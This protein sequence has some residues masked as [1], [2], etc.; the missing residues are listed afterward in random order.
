M[1]DPSS[2]PSDSSR[3]QLEGQVEAAMKHVQPAQ[4]QRIRAHHHPLLLPLAD[5]R[6]QV[7]L[8]RR[9]ALEGNRSSDEQPRGRHDQS[10][11]TRGDPASEGW[12][13]AV[14][15]RFE[16]MH[17]CQPMHVPGGSMHASLQFDF[18]EDITPSTAHL[19][20]LSHNGSMDEHPKELGR[21]GREDLHQEAYI[22][23]LTSAAKHYAEASAHAEG[24]AAY[25]LHYSRGLVL[26]ELASKVGPA[27]PEHCGFLKQACEA[28]QAASSLRPSA[29]AALYNWG[30]ALSDLARVLKA[31]GNAPVAAA[32]A[33]APAGPAARSPRV[34]GDHGGSPGKQQGS[35]P[36]NSTSSAPAPASALLR[37]TSAG[38][39]PG[40][41]HALGGALALGT[42]L[43]A[44]R[45][46]LAL[47][48]E[49]YAEALRWQPSN[50]QALNN[51]GLVMQEMSLDCESM[52]ERDQLVRYAL[53]KFRWVP[54]R[55]PRGAVRMRG[56]GR[57]VGRERLH[58]RWRGAAYMP[59]GWGVGRVAC[60]GKHGGDHPT[61]D[62][63]KT[64]Q[65]RPTPQLRDP[66]APG[67]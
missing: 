35:G 51:W 64:L 32:A 63:S 29:P 24:S 8:W 9:G 1:L 11:W 58:L 43:A 21:S 15:A 47:A 48:S 18:G 4:I 50:P 13:G 56:Q 30:V 7:V 39:P 14:V 23:D 26:Q 59:G 17:A 2:I 46:C 5:P 6:L 67:L 33:A 31:S 55:A 41:P 19:S 37:A 3:A 12:A 65:P 25:D 22:K 38:A 16:P 45:R 40:S 36:H 49:K 44:A 57:F 60:G 62:P 20:T 61:P 27:T 52:A 34:T 42:G 10:G 28:Y 66:H 53:E 54:G